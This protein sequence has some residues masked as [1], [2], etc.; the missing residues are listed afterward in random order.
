MWNKFVFLSVKSG[1]PALRIINAESGIFTDGVWYSNTSYIP[2]R[3]TIGGPYSRG[4]VVY[5]YEPQ[6]SP[7]RRGTYSCEMCWGMLDGAGYCM[8]CTTCADC[9]AVFNDCLCYRPT[10]AE[11]AD[12]AWWEE[13]YTEE[14]PPEF[15]GSPLVTGIV[16]EEMADKWAERVRAALAKNDLVGAEQALSQAPPRQILPPL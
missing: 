3:R 11:P 10:S 15:P 1:E 13:E 2:P 16:D 8:D 9:S 7:V 5:V 14:D 4:E 6:T 12:V